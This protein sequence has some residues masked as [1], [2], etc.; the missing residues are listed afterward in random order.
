[1]YSTELVT[2]D[3]GEMQK[4]LD[5]HTVETNVKYHENVTEVTLN[6][7]P[8]NPIPAGYRLIHCFICFMNSFIYSQYLFTVY[9]CTFFIIFFYWFSVYFYFVVDSI[10]FNFKI[11]A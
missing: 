9:L 10:I 4:H 2:V 3:L 1:M 11:I 8:T 5:I 6:L 7:V